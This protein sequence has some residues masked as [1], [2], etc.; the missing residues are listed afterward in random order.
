MS[1]PEMGARLKAARENMKLTQKDASEKADIAKVQTLSAYERGVNSPPL[2]TLKKLSEL[3]QVS[4]DF[5]LFGSEVEERRP[6]SDKDYFLQF[7]TAADHLE[8]PIFEE[9]GDQLPF[10][11]NYLIK[12]CPPG[13]FMDTISGWTKGEF[14][15]FLLRWKQ[16]RNAKAIGAI[17]NLDYNYLIDK[18]ATSIPDDL[19][20]TTDC[21]LPF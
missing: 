4:T 1:D 2:E 5:L 6:K 18:L 13:V 15:A 9:G 11:P 8:F 20:L 14:C 3:Y 19:D 10:D 16:L 17:N 21:E 12:V 7:I